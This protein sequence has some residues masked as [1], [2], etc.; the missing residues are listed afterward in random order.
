MAILNLGFLIKIS[1]SFCLC[2]SLTCPL[3]AVLLFNAELRGQRATLQ[4]EARACHSRT[5]A[6]RVAAFPGMHTE[7]GAPDVYRS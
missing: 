3:Q 7:L 1:Y 5:E 6:A 4:P 2:L